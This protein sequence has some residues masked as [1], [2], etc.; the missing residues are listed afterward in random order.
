MNHL[1]KITEN[2]YKEIRLK[3]L[4]IQNFCLNIFLCNIFPNDILNFIFT[5]YYY[6]IDISL[7]SIGFGER[8]NILI[9]NNLYFLKFN[10]ESKNSDGLNIKTIDKNDRKIQNYYSDGKISYIITTNGELFGIGQNTY[11]QLGLGDFDSVKSSFKKID[12]PIVKSISFN[13]YFTYIQ[14][15]D[16][17]LYSCGSNYYNLL[18]NKNYNI[19]EN[20]CYFTN[21]GLNVTSFSCGRHHSLILTKDKLYGFGNNYD[22]QLGKFEQFSDYSYLNILFDINKIISIQCG[23]RWSFILTTDGLYSTGENEHGQLGHSIDFTLDNE[24]IV[25][26]FTL[27]ENLSNILSFKLFATNSLVLTKDGLYG[28]GSTLSFLTNNHS[29]FTKIDIQNVIYYTCSYIDLIVLN[30]KGLFTTR[31]SFDEL[32]KRLHGKTKDEFIKINF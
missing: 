31:N 3:Y 7:F 13:N 1:G 17:F 12:V 5:L 28:C 32:S 25:F 19:C 15:K 16:G 30:D 26:N 14:T 20:S 21:T 4:I 22:Y 10:D 23:I 8:L 24:K 18:L 6:L 2:I 27:I 9:D 11:G 29:I